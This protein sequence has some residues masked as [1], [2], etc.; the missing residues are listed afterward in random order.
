MSRDDESRREG[1]EVGYRKPPKVHQFPKGRTG[2]PHGRPKK[3]KNMEVGPPE[4]NA[5]PIVRMVLEEAYR[6]VRL[7]E[8]DKFIDLPVIQAVMRGLSVAAMKGDRRSQLAFAD[9]VQKSEERKQQQQLELFAALTQYKE[10]FEPEFRRCEE[11][12]LPMPTIRPH[13]DDVI[14]DPRMGT[15]FVYGPMTLE[16]EKTFL[17]GV[18]QRDQTETELNEYWK[19]RDKEPRNKDWP[20]SI[21][22]WQEFYD[23]INDV[24]PPRF[25]KNLKRRLHALPGSGYFEM[26]PPPRK[27]KARAKPAAT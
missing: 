5:D 16:E 3:Q 1:Y 21:L 4:Y 25:R 10:R 6:T 14:V 19:L 22:R 17:E 20:Q 2:N 23:T 8:G 18:E 15:A 12:G 9:L 7:K 11:N 26:P 13:P 27:R 24:L